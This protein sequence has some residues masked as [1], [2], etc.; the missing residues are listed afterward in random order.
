MA[1][2]DLVPFAAAHAIVI[3]AWVA[4]W[5][6][7]VGIGVLVL[8]GLGGALRGWTDVSTSLWLGLAGTIAFLQ[9]W[10]LV[11]PID[12]RA[13][14]VV[15]GAAA[16][17]LWTSRGALVGL[18]RIA[19]P[20][21]VFVAL[22]LVLLWVANRGLGPSALY[23]TGM[24][25]QP[26][27]NWINAFAVV[28]GL[29]NLHGRLAFN[30]SSFLLAALFDVGAA[31]RLVFHALNGWLFGA[32]IVEGLVCVWLARARG[33][34]SPAALFTIAVLPYALHGALRREIASL[35]TDAAVAMMLLVGTRALF[36]S[37]IQPATDRAAR[38]NAWAI[39]ATLFAAAV[40]IKLSAGVYV[41]T[42][43]IV[44]M[45]WLLTREAASETAERWAGVSVARGARWLAP[46]VVLAVAWIV[47]GIW[48]SG[49]PLYPTRVF[50]VGVDWRVP[51][52]QAAAEHAWI[53]M[54]ARA[55][56]ANAIYPGLSW[57]RPWLQTIVT[58]VELIALFTAPLLVALG[59]AAW[60]VAGRGR[61]R[62]PW[63][64]AV[65]WLSLPTVCAGLFWAATAPH[66]RMIQGVVW[67]WMGILASAHALAKPQRASR[68][69]AASLGGFL[70]LAA[71][72]VRSALRDSATGT[73][74]SAVFTLPAMEWGRPLPTPPLTRY[75]TTHGVTLAVPPRDNRC[76]NGPLLCTPHP[77]PALALRDPAD[78]GRGFRTE[79]GAWLPERWPNP[80]I[81]FLPWWRCVEAAP[82]GDDQAA[83]RCVAA[84]SRRP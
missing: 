62:R 10:H 68:L 3:V 58:N 23:D 28:P 37:V 44:G 18:P 31:D 78:P 20:P 66:P 42:A 84:V 12:A 33:Q 82:R 81:G 15:A 25:H 39:A 59:L 34:A 22:A 4:G 75:V 67:G 48:L 50:P 57:G 77:T 79:G 1:V 19:L 80:F 63:S 40:T 69:A 65:V 47:R 60:W 2:G 70:L 35:S 53:V 14:L 43:L 24:Y 45:V 51:A 30:D 11:L 21:G 83:A 6:M 16:A 5:V 17:G 38:G 36:S 56:N 41:A 7:M 64:D 46:T 61:T 54:S 8:R 27:V 49:Y 26:A 29:G 9:L 72:S 73:L 32:L 13:I 71:L 55:L 52:E 74:A 76:G